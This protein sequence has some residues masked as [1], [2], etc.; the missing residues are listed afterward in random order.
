MLSNQPQPPLKSQILFREW[1]A[2]A[3][4]SGL[5]VLLA[6]VSWFP[7][8]KLEKEVASYQ[9]AR[10]N[11][12]TIEILVEG[13][14]GQPGIYSFPPGVTVREVLKTIPLLKEANRKEIPYRK[15]FLSSQT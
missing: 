13:A 14:V 7:Q 2:I 9:L 11:Q 15:V 3:L 1:I 12:P 8:L 6:I 4:V 5:V 10:L